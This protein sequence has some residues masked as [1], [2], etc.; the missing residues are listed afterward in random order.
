MNNQFS[1]DVQ[2][3]M[4]LS[5]EE[6]GRLRSR[7]ILPE[8]LLLAMLRGGNG[9]VVGILNKLHADTSALKKD[10][11]QGMQQAGY[12]NLPMDEDEEIAIS[13]M[14]TRIMRLSVL[15]ARFLKSQIADTEHVLLAILKAGGTL[16]SD[17]LNR[18]RVNYS[19]VYSLIAAKTEPSDSMDYTKP[20]LTSGR[21]RDTITDME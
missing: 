20:S 14:A 4:L 13:A 9:P 3:L 21:A 12:T 15:E 18:Q 2:Q 10:I 11:E 1:Q 16:A 6:A 17:S 8:H 7:S 5:R 19:S